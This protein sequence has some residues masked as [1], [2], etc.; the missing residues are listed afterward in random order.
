MSRERNFRLG[1][2][3]VAVV[4]LAA[5]TAVIWRLYR[6]DSSL[7]RDATFSAEQITPN[8]DGVTDAVRIG[9]ELA[10][11]ATVSI[12]FENDEGT[13]YYFREGQMRGADEYEV[14]FSG[15]VDGF[16][17]PDE[18]IQGE[19][20]SR[21]LPNGRYQWV[22]A[23]TDASGRTEEATGPLTI[24]DADETL[25]DMRDFSLDRTLFTP[26]Q[27]GIDDRVQVQYW[28]AKDAIVRVFLEMPDGTELPIPETERDVPFGTAGRHY[29][30][31]EGG[32][33]DKETPPPDGVYPVVAIAEDE[34]G[35]KIRVEKTLEIALGGVPR[36]DIFAPAAGDTFEVSATAVTICNTMYFTATVENYGETPIR[37]TGPFPETV[38]DSDWNYNTLGW[39]TES[40]AW[41]FAIGYENEIANYPYRWAIGNPDDL[42]EIDGHLYLMPGDRALVTGGIRII[43]PFGERNPQ[44]L[45]AGL[46]H[47][48]VEISEFNNRV[49]PKQI[50]LDMPDPTAERPC[51][52]R[53]VPEKVEAETP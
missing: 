5:A 14:F 13:R 47:E 22:I 35:Q 50:L 44:P 32:V 16:T 10:D 37:T 3:I 24:A 2:I 11:S 33:D 1:V 6:G 15:V 18:T 53:P 41:R 45:W 46:I 29:Y 12:Y 30:D 4:V 51:E 34:E 48:D 43:A 8:A 25:P 38:Y 19:I 42:T 52:A 17:L 23:A 40:G 49:D 27:D 28:L 26:N 31:Y 20:L 7:L 36:A 21:I 39:F 9:Y